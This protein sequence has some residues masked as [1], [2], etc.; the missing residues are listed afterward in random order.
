MTS[1]TSLDPGSWAWTDDPPAASLLEAGALTLGLLAHPSRWI[2]RRVER[3]SFRDAHS[4]R[5]Q[6]LLDLWL[7]PN[8]PP[9]A[10]QRL[11]RVYIAP[12]FLI[13]RDHEQLLESSGRHI[14][15][16]TYSTVELLDSSGN[17][18]PRITGRTSARIA[19][20]ALATRANLVLETKA[21]D[22]DLLDAI[23]LIAVG[24]ESA[25]DLALADVFETGHDHDGSRAKLRD[26]QIFKDLA[27]A[28][29][30]HTIVFTI[31]VGS[32]PPHRSIITLS[33]EEELQNL[34]QVWHKELRRSLG[35]KSKVCQVRLNE[36][37]ASATYHVEIDVPG[38]LELTAIGLFGERYHIFRG[39]P[40]PQRWLQRIK[41]RLHGQSSDPPDAE[42]AP[43]PRRDPDGFY[44]EQVGQQGAGHIYIPRPDGRRVGL[45][46][47]KLRARRRGFLVGALFSS[48]VIFVTLVF[49]WIEAKSIAHAGVSD[50]T[51]AGLLL[52]P[53]LLAAY[54]ASPAKH[55]I[56][57]RMLTWARA[58]LLAN[59]V[60]P[61]VAAAGL[62]TTKTPGPHAATDLNIT[63]QWLPVIAFAFVV[64]FSLSFIFP[65][66]H[67]ES[68]YDVK[69]VD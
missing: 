45:A 33:Y 47:V 21:L 24:D 59:A 39:L 17:Q 25:R 44:V 34:H 4:A 12:L 30:D 15:V 58:A 66:I 54:I 13:A 31:F 32:E 42:V 14:P 23:T 16:P 67:G 3:I 62:I 27:Y 52:V 60:L 51:V 36:I 26:D 57:A 49:Y 63:W 69:T 8:L 29:A 11:D 5:H 9:V 68:R 1:G 41:S 35:W 48:V 18:L 56:T 61:F 65:R 38:E 50:A 7:P 20:V 28:F 40:T 37:G 2:N 22:E 53:T 64:L 10:K 6:I 43:L 55:D 46:W 19:A